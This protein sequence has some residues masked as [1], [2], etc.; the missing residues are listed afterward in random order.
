VA[1]AVGKREAEDILSEVFI[2]VWQNLKKFNSSKASF[3]TWIFSIARNSSID[4]LRKKKI[5]LFSDLES[6]GISDEIFQDTIADEGSLSDENLDKIQDLDFL[7]QALEKLSPAEKSILL[8]RYQEDMSFEEIS[9]IFQKSSNTIKSI[10]RRTII[11]L[12]DVFKN[13]G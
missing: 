7:N 13:R 6:M 10:Y 12:R 8:L 11:K 2:K 4:F 3:K 9:E 5:T 1:R